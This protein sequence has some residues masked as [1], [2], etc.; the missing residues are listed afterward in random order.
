MANES[1]LQEGEKLLSQENYND[2]ILVF[3]KALE[4]GEDPKK[5]I[6]RRAW[7]YLKADQPD[8]AAEEFTNAIELDPENAHFY[9]ERGVARLNLR[10]FSS[11]ILDLNYA[12]ELDPDNPYRYSSRGY[13]RD[14]LGDLE[15]AFQDYSKALSLDPSDVITQ[16]N[17]ELLQDKMKYSKPKTVHPIEPGEIKPVINEQENSPE[18]T[19][20]FKDY[21][22][23]IGKVLST[24]E[25]FKD[26]MKYLTNRK[27]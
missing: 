3:T 9:S 13:V 27:G 5:V 24:K 18:P 19:P 10:Q 14:R 2:A 15:G 21:I 11:A 17:L 20:G 23:E 1:L 8:R 25:G 16:N 26:F 4:R 7:A 22:R 12:L 6:P